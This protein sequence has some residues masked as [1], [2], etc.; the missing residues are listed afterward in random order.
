MREIKFRAWDIEFE[1][2]ARPEDI[3]IQGD[4]QAW[5]DRRASDYGDVIDTIDGSEQGAIIEQFTGLLDKNGKEI[6]E[7]DIVRM[8]NGNEYVKEWH[9]IEDYDRGGIIGVGFSCYRNL[10]G[11]MVEEI[12]GNIHESA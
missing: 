11:D 8:D 12:I 5:I 9:E 2:W 1:R 4:G 10:S 3:S 6:Y 7:G